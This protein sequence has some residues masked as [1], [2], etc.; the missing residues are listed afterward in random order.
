MLMSL[1]INVSNSGKVVVENH[2]NLALFALSINA[3]GEEHFQLTNKC[4]HKT[5][6]SIVMKFRFGHSVYCLGDSSEILRNSQA[7]PYS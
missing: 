7:V 2:R 3:N 6:F 4:V 1:R 5:V